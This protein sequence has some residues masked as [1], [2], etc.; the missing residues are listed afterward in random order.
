L[1]RSWWYNLVFYLLTV[2]SLSCAATFMHF[3]GVSD[4]SIMAGVVVLVLPMHLVAALGYRFF[5]LVVPRIAGRYIRVLL[6]MTRKKVLTEQGQRQILLGTSY[7][8]LV[9]LVAV[10]GAASSAAVTALLADAARVSPFPTRLYL[11][12]ILTETA[13]LLLFAAV[14]LVMRYF[15]LLA[16]ASGTEL[17]YYERWSCQAA[18]PTLR[19]AA[20][21]HGIQ[22]SGPNQSGENPRAGSV[23]IG[24]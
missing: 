3:H 4:R 16:S 12:I 7:A 18:Y 15:W 5:W 6:S 24:F 10:L 19:T 14:P 8:A 9:T 11:L 1:F 21:F 13:L 22:M 20:A 23:R 2:G 17:R